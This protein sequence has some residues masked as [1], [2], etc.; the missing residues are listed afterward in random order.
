MVWQALMAS[1]ATVVLAA[2]VVTAT[3]RQYP[4]RMVAMAASVVT[5]AA[6]SVP[7]MQAL[8]VLAA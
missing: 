3:L 2:M 6:L 5:V 4:A 1:T 8:A 7:A